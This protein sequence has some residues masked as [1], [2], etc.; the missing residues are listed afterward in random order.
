MK[1]DAVDVFEVLGPSWDEGRTGVLYVEIRTDEG[2][3]GLFGP[4]QP[5]QADVIRRFLAPFLVG[6]DPLATEALHDQMLRLDRHGR[7]GLF[8][9]GLSPVDCAL[10]D[11]KAKV[12]DLPV[13][14]LLGGPTRTSVPAYASL[15]GHSVD[16]DAAATTA[17]EHAELGYEAQKWFFG[18]GPKH[19]ADGM[20]KNVDL[21][22]ALRDAL[23]AHYRVMFDASN[24]W[25]ADYAVAMVRKLARVEPAWVEEPVP[26]ERVSTLRRIRDAAPVP[27]ATG[28]HVYTRWQ[29]K[30]LLEAG[31]VDVLQTDP[32]WCG[33]ITE[34]VKICALA[35][36]FDIPV[37]AHGHSLLP[38]LHVA[39]AQP[40][41]V[42]PEVEF[43]TLAQ[44]MKQHFHT[45]RR[46]PV[47]GQLEL[48]GEPGLGLALDDDEIASMRPIE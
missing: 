27:I 26:P 19:G 2:P 47:A 1:I 23:G 15:L 5:A 17:V 12:L 7:T 10:W 40:A 39:G 6:R 21:A 37:I 31:S 46:E 35:S 3:S 4:V 33:G 18:Y 29:V 30:Q 34:Q 41:S 42:V 24:R 8:L 22:L 38:A 44:P 16:P 14:R 11:L 48:P 25:T 32:D 20:T 36:A 45:P 9:T 28:E 43:L 13:W